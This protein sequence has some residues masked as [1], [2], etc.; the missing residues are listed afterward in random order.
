MSADERH[1]VL[2]IGGQPQLGADRR[3]PVVARAQPHVT[4]VRASPG[5][6]DEIARHGQL[7]M[8]RTADGSVRMVGDESALE[9]LDVGARLFVQAWQQTRKP[10]RAGDGRPWDAPGFE[11]P[12][13]PHR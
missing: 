7:A 13:P 5:D 2:V 12:G 4:V 1:E 11:P 10:D 9:G 8:A 3:W 6:L